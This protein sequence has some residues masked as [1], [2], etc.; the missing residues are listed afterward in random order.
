MGSV[1]I[2]AETTGVDITIIRH[3]HLSSNRG[4]TSFNSTSLTPLFLYTWCLWENK[5]Q[6]IQAP[7]KLNTRVLKCKPSASDMIIKKPE[8]WYNAVHVVTYDWAI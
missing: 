7:Y 4:P 5:R 2:N 6:Q 1:Q 8:E 3:S